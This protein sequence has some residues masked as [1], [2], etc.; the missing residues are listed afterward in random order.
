MKK[1]IRDALQE[2]VNRLE[3]TLPALRAGR[4]AD[5]FAND[6]FEA[7]DDLR[8]LGQ[9]LLD[10]DTRVNYP[11]R[12]RQ[13]QE[14]W[15]RLQLLLRARAPE[16]VRR[17]QPVF[18]VAEQVLSIARDVEP[19]KEGHLGFLAIAREQ[20]GFLQSEYGFAVAREE[21]VRIRF[22][23]GVIFVELAWA[24]HVSGSCSFGFESNPSR[25]F[26]IDDLLFLHGDERHR[27]LA[28]ELR[29]DS[30]D[31]IEKWLGFLAAIFRRYGH[32]LLTGQPEMFER[33]SAAQE[34]RDRRRG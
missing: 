10:G 12:V 34:A 26:W 22:S 19:P 1:P 23:S 5:A 15:D 24:K 27:S 18:D 8:A 2:L 29:L 4:D 13:E 31:A 17:Y 16:D 3:Q 21:P 14:L 33:L 7:A 32:D 11:A 20:F 30:G 28:D 25:L 6:L 9:Y